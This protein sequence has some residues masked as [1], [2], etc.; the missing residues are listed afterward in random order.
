[1][2]YRTKGDRVVASPPDGE[3]FTGIGPGAITE[4]DSVGHPSPEYLAA[5]E[6]SLQAGR[7]ADRAPRGASHMRLFLMMTAVLAVGLGGCGNISWVRGNDDAFFMTQEQVDAKDDATC[8]SLGAVPS[9]SVYVDCR[10]RL[11]TNRS[12]EDS[13]RRL[14]P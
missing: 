2:V 1:M 8:K 6:E 10:L 12:S 7:G 13:L 5:I 9:T 11:R 3:S 4:V 14:T